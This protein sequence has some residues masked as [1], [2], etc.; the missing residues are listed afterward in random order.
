MWLFIPSVLITSAERFTSLSVA[1]VLMFQRGFSSMLL[2][3]ATDARYVPCAIMRRTSSRCQV[4]RKMNQ[5]RRGC[6][7]S[8]AVLC[9]AIQTWGQI[10]M[11]YFRSLAHTAWAIRL[12][13]CCPLC[14]NFQQTSPVKER[15]RI[16]KKQFYSLTAVLSR[17]K[18]L[19]IFT[20]IHASHKAIVKNTGRCRQGQWKEDAGNEK[21]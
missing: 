16:F 4:I 13:L 2:L 3:S 7:P 9:Y 11:P 15:Q 6:V 5:L 19:Q 12:T 20:W 8:F 18:Y 1:E 14:G 17:H 10:S 21:L